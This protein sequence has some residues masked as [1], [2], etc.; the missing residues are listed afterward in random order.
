MDRYIAKENIRHFRDRLWSEV[1]Q[2]ARARLRELLVAE[3]DKLAANLELLADIDRHISDGNRRIDK[4]RTLINAM[5]RNGHNGLAQAR[6]LLDCMMETQ[7]LHQEY[8]RSIST[9]IQQSQL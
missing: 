7:R 9:M 3:E 2:G 6:A 4:Q 5:E 1:D 8:R